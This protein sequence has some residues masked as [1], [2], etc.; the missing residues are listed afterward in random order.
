[1]EPEWSGRAARYGQAARDTAR[2]I[3]GAQIA[4]PAGPRWPMVPGAPESADATLYGAG[5]GITLFLADLARALDDADLAAAAGQAARFVAGTPDQGYFGLYTGYA[6]MTF[7]VRHAA[8][9]LGDDSL[10]HQAAGMLDHLA[11]AAVPVGDGLE[12]P[13]FPSGRGPWQE[14]FHGT[15]G[16]ALVAAGLGRLDTAVSAGCRLI[17]L[18]Q[19]AGTGRWWR[20]R[21][22]DYKP[23][24]NM[25]HG[26][27]GIAYAL[28]TLAQLTGEPRFAAA[29]LDGAAYLLS[30][31]R[32]RDGSCAVHHHEVDG[33]GLYSLGFCSWPA[34]L[35]CLFVRMHQL[36]GDSHWL[37]WAQRAAR[38]ITRSGLPARRY[39]GFWD[40]VGQCCGSAGVADFFLGLHALTGEPGHLRFALTVL[41]DILDR[42]V[43]DERGMCW[44]NVEHTA[45]PPALPA[46]TGWM[47]GAAGIGAALLRA[48]QILTGSGAGP[49]LP[50]WPFPSAVASPG[51]AAIS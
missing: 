43:A 8:A 44:Q 33:T 5:A 28:G 29:A 27:A 4:S 37:G 42:A 6:G 9:V 21:P 50:S 16:I 48:R 40:N 38:T 17:E 31:A 18:A 3:I 23:A 24:P 51:A 30:I 26:T 46:Q 1:V 15:A 39:P 41:D 2:W 7:A 10:R 34:G 22:D 13:A 32:T 45:T 11:A 14:L 20:S 47:Q 36:T 25:A 19:P 35:G 12:W 49:W